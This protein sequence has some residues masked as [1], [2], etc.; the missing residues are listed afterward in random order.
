MK[1]LRVS[2]SAMILL[3]SPLAAQEQ[4][5]RVPE[6]P[7]TPPQREGAERPPLPPGAPRE[8]R[9]REPR[10]PENRDAREPGERPTRPPFPPRDGERRGDGPPGE[11]PPGDREERRS[12]RPLP[13]EGDGGPR[14]ERGSRD[15]EFRLFERK[16]KPTAYVGVVTSPATP[17]LSTQLGLG[18]GFGLVVDEVVPESPAKAA[19][20][21]R[22]DVLKQ[23]NEQQLVDPAQLA[24]L[25]RSLGKD[26]EVTI[27]IIRKGQEQK[28][29]LKIGEKMLPEREQPDRRDG[30][31]FPRRREEGGRA[32][33]PS[34]P[35]RQGSR[36]ENEP[37]GG[38][39]PAD[40]LRDIRPGAPEVLRADWTN[41][42]SRWDASRAR[43]TMRDHDG[44]VEVL[45]R[46]GRR[47]LTARGASGDTVFTGPVDTDDQRKAVPAPF[48]DKLS[49][50][51]LPEAIRTP[52]RDQRRSD[53][54][55]P[56]DPA[57]GQPP[58]EVQ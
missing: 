2:I 30:P 7:A 3:A 45:I 35:D 57:A 24:T 14:F 58:R 21:E 10:G 31:G 47:T 54:S 18:E 20:I 12:E 17:A 38:L 11:R 27:T 4:P 42:R 26:K 19:G 44:E 48:R 29:T 33:Q 41:G 8:P 34:N 5:P 55:P 16:L 37:F 28:L 22:Y 51:E 9:V 1:P 36:G 43:V 50:L 52:T 23:F 32:P 15:A 39:K 6:P 46:D 13:R 53:G 56:L 49:A 25:V 40:L